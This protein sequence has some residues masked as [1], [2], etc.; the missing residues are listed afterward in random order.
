MG[1]RCVFKQHTGT[2]LTT[3]ADPS[4]PI[5][6]RDR[7]NLRSYIHPDI[8]FAYGTATSPAVRE[9]AEKAAGGP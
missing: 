8:A 2:V 1:G 7:P 4:Q 3:S 9:A 5:G 6:N